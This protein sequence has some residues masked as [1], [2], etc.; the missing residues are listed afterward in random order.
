[1]LMGH[2]FVFCYNLESRYG[3]LWLYA[4][5]ANLGYGLGLLDVSLKP[6]NNHQFPL[7]IYKVRRLRN[8]NCKMCQ[9]SRTIFMV[10]PKYL[11]GC[12]SPSPRNDPSKVNLHSYR[13]IVSIT[14]IWM[15]SIFMTMLTWVNIKIVIFHMANFVTMLAFNHLWLWRRSKN[16]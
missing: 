16:R 11:L 5:V 12:W 13:R 1:M 2:C 6:V 14:S 3:W 8:I 15:M 4:H 10:W 9:Y 7:V